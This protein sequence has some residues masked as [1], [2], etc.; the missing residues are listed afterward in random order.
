MGHRARHTR[1]SRRGLTRVEALIGGAIMALGI[2]GYQLY[3]TSAGAAANDHEAVTRASAIRTAAETWQQENGTSCP[4]IS[5]LVH[6]R[7]LDDTQR[8]DHPWGENYRLSC[9]D[10]GVTVVSPGPDCKR[11]T[12]DD[13]RVGS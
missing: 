2:G 1:L 13:V 12:G 9:G 10:D 3:S 11:N 6:D 5:Q 8:T 7:H 4:S